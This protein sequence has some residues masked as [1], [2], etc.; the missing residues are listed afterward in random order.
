MSYFMLVSLKRQGSQK[1]WKNKGQFSRYK[2]VLGVDQFGENEITPG[3]FND[4]FQYCT[5]TIFMP[6]SK[7]FLLIFTLFGN[8]LEKLFYLEKPLKCIKS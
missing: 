8:T 3:N 5:T 7:L 2:E 6:L 1:T 4:C